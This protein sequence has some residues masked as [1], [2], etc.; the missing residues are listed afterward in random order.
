MAGGYKE[1]NRKPKGGVD[2]GPIMLGGLA[3]IFV[4][5]FVIWLGGA[6]ATSLAGKP[7]SRPPFGITMMLDLII[8]GPGHVWPEVNAILIILC[9]TLVLGAVLGL[10]YGGM[11]LWSRFGKNKTGNGL[12][13][14]KELKRFTY[15]ERA[16]EAVRLRPRTLDGVDPKKLHSNDVGAPIGSWKNKKLYSGWEDVALAIMAPRS[17]KT[18]AV[19]V[20]QIIS[21]PGPVIVTSNKSDIYSITVSKRNRDHPNANIWVFDP[22]EVVLA[23]PTWYWNPLDHVEDFDSALELASMFLAKREADDKGG[24]NAEFFESSGRNYFAYLLL[25]AALPTKK[26]P[27]VTLREVDSWLDMREPMAAVFRLH[28]ANQAHHAKALSAMIDGPNETVGGIIAVARDAAVALKSEK[29]LQWV[30]PSDDRV[31][32]TPLDFVHSEDTLYLM[33]NEKSASAAAPLIAA[34]ASRVFDVGADEAA[35]QYRQRLDPPLVAVLDEAANI[36][37]IP[38]LPGG[39]S[40]YGSRGLCVMS[41]FQNP[42]QPVRVWGENAWKEMWAA[43]TIKL[44][45][46]GMDDATFAEDISKLVGDIDVDVK[47][48]SKGDNGSDSVTVRQERILP[49]SD[50]RTIESGKMLLLATATTPAMLDQDRYYAGPH[51]EELNSDEKK[52]ADLITTRARMMDSTGLSSAPALPAGITKKPAL[53]SAAS[54]VGELENPTHHAIAQTSSYPVEAK[55]D[56]SPRATEPTS[57]STLNPGSYSDEAMAARKSSLSADLDELL[58]SLGIDPEP[59]ARSNQP[60]S[61]KRPPAPPSTMKRPAALLE[62]KESKASAKKQSETE[63]TPVNSDDFFI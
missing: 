21:A 61:P 56:D 7:N 24:G 4:I 23:D 51:K 34:F 43:A 46:P 30:V 37:K 8:K 18:S 54:H 19:G 39:Y 22:Q 42:H 31:E 38:G 28:A 6:M 44:I 27:P 17:G 45:G 9:I 5:S 15:A 48:V 49:A 26:S 53:Q 47:T 14:G 55:T 25:A 2:T 41:I 3:L 62:S 59:D 11:K 16:K 10:L 1:S 20:P 40:H 50:I 33:S 35:K 52:V 57:T 12:A 63:G 36:C 60:K 29:I 13:E 32:F 58:L